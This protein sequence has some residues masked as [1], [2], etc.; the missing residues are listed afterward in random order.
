MILALF[1]AVLAGTLGAPSITALFAAAKV[2]NLPM[3]YVGAVGFNAT[4]GL[5]PLSRINNTDQLKSLAN[6]NS[7]PWD[8]QPIR[9]ESSMSRIEA[10]RQKRLDRMMARNDL[11]GRDRANLEA[12]N[13]VV[14]GQSL[15]KTFGK[16]IF[17]LAM[18]SSALISF[19]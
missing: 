3:T 9:S 4:A 10:L 11:M 8:Y 18:F 17:S 19:F 13:K 2:P 5:V 12:I 7:I 1:I 16:I 15:L 6:P 14:K